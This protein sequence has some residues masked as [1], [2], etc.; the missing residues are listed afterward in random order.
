MAN[1]SKNNS[2][3]D[4]KNLCN[5]VGMLDKFKTLIDININ[6]FSNRILKL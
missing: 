6:T 5:S 3:S 1:L 4:F 2:S